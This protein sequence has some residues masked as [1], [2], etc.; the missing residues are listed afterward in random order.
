[1]MELTQEFLSQ[2]IG[3][4]L[5]LANVEAGYLKRGDIK[6]IKLQ[7]K[8]DNQKL[9]VSFAWFAKNRGQPLEPG[10][11]WVKIKAQDL[12]FKL[13]D[14]QITDEGDGR[15]SLWDPVL[16]ESAVL[17][18]PDDELRIGHS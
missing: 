12:T 16:S 10:D 15:I 14:C 2:Y 5:V 8:P 11:D 6:E 1:M 18:L 17:L 7:G 3:G 9:N 4:Q 13:R